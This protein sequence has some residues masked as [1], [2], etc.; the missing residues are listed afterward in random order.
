VIVHLLEFRIA[1]GHEAEV[2]AFLR[3]LPAGDGSLAGPVQH[4]VGRRLGR[5]QQ[6]YVLTTVWR[7]QGSFGKGVDQNGLPAYLAHQAKL[8]S[9]CGASAL[10]VLASYGEGFAGARILR[11]YRAFV[12]PAAVDAW[13]EGAVHQAVKLAQSAGLRLVLAGAR[14]PAEDPTGDVPVMAIS[15]WRD[16]NSVLTATGGHLDQLVGET[17]LVDT[18]KPAGLDHYQLL[19]REGGPAE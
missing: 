7:D 5:D 2:V 8:L 1:P 12:A 4:C 14:R 18:E 6:E 19:D 3:R 17:G 10:D 11:V 15:A 9:D 16:W 13:R